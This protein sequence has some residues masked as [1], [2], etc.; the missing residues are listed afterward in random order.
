MINFFKK[1]KP[2]PPENKIPS[3]NIEKTPVTESQDPSLQDVTRLDYQDH[4]AYTAVKKDY[5]ARGGRLYVLIEPELSESEKEIFALLRKMLINELSVDLREIK[6]REEAA[7]R[8]KNK[9]IHL[10]RKHKIKI[11]DP[12]LL[13]ILYYI[14]RDYAHLGKIEPLMHDPMVEEI[15]CDGTNIPLYIWHREHGSLPTNIVFENE[16]ELENYV[17][18]IAR[19]TGKQ[20]SNVDPVLDAA[21]PDGGRVNLTLGSE[22]T[23]RG[24]TFTIR[25]LRK[26]SLSII[27]L[28]KYNTLSVE[29]AAYLWILI[30]RKRTML[31]VGGESSGKTTTLSAITSFISPSL[32]VVTIEDTPELKLRH[33][34]WIPAVTRQTYSGSPRGEITQFDLLRSAMRQ[35]PDVIIVKEAKGKEAHVLFQAMATG[36]G[37]FSSIHADSIEMAIRILNSSPMFVQ[38]DL[39]VNTLDVILYQIKVKIGNDTVRRIFQISE[40]VR[41]DSASNQILLDDVFAW[42]PN[43]DKYNFSGRSIV[44]EKIA[45]KMIGMS[46]DQVILE[47][48]K[49][50]KI[51]QWMVK[52]DVHSY[53]EVND[54]IMEY[55]KDP[56]KFYEKNRI[57]N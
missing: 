4:A 39:I 45:A 54:V 48:E 29:M 20:I 35:R 11:S 55:Y 41:L 25:F 15:S 1:N 52:N 50:K 43:T 21:L 40:I 23:K 37:G 49:R 38:K 33:E 14:I 12:R 5:S 30:E 51:L 32:K 57:L 42:D 22:I 26:D 9:V 19:L 47:F 10:V 7:Y 16:I 31:V 53:D 56:E 13:K 44:F 6:T 28:I 36:H 34:N 17:R 18:R 3:D 24:S 8:L 46:Q 27:D 2:K